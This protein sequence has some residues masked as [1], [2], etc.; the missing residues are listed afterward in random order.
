[1]TV[2][3]AEELYG[4]VDDIPTFKEG[5]ESSWTRPLREKLKPQPSLDLP[6]SEG[7]KMSAEAG[8]VLVGRKPVASYIQAILTAV[9]R[10]ADEVVLKARG[11]NISRAVDVSQ[12]AI[13][14]VLKGFEVSSVTIGSEEVTG[15]SGGSGTAEAGASGGASRPRRVSTIEIR[16]KKKE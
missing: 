5:P 15:V 6:R 10:G 1:L 8:V 7:C 12:L 14:T 3:Q 4:L 16:L 11:M 2:N 13:K 9:A